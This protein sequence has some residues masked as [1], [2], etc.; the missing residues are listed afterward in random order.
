M[1]QATVWV[2]G[3][4]ASNEKINQ[5]WLMV[6]DIKVDDEKSSAFFFFYISECKSTHNCDD[7]QL[8]ESSAVLKALNDIKRNGG[9]KA[10]M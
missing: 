5:H 6:G 2:T 7:V 8:E 1:V 10:R 9:N 4:S 3:D